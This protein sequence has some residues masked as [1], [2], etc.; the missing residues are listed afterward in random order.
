MVLDRALAATGDEN[1]L[2]D[3]RLTRLVHG[4]LDQRTID[5]RQHLFGDRLGRRKEAGAEPR[6]RE[7]SLADGFVRHGLNHSKTWL[8]VYETS[9]AAKPFFS[10]ASLGGIT[11]RQ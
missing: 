5:H 11:A 9:F 8:I 1:H 3:L 4:I 10:L 2:L 6:H 7:N